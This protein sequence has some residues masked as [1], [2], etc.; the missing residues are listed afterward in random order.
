VS[1]RP[2]SYPC[3]GADGWPLPQLLANP[4]FERLQ[5]GKLRFYVGPLLQ[6]VRP[7]RFEDREEARQ[8]RPL[9]APRLVHV[10]QFADLGQRQ[11][12]ALAAQRQ[13]QARAVA[14]RIDAAL[15]GAL[16]REQAVVLVEADRARRDVEFARQL[17]DGK[18]A[19]FLFALLH[20]R[21]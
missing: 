11:A 21:V 3:R 19:A 1:T 12:E 9:V 14:R 13:F 8:L 4:L 7:V 10:D 16:G 18:L 2:V 5:L 15:A 20:D 17:A 6:Q